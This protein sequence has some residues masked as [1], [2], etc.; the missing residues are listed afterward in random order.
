VLP[1]AYEP[2]LRPC[3]TPGR[4]AG[5]V[6]EPKYDGIRAIVEVGPAGVSP[7]LAERHRQDRQFPGI[8][9]AL[10]SLGKRLKATAVLDGEIVPSTR[11]AR[12]WL[13]AYSG[14]DPSDRAR[15]DRAR[16]TRQPPCLIVFDILRDGLKDLRR[17]PLVERRLKL[18]ERIQPRGR[19]RRGCASAKSRSTMARHVA[20]GARRRLGRPHRQ[21]SALAVPQ[22]QTVAGVA[23]DEAPETAGVR[24]RRMDAPRQTR[25]YFGS[26]L[27][28]YYDDAVSC[29]GR[30]GGDWLRS[31]ELDRVWNLLE[32]RKTD[33]RPFADNFKTAKRLRG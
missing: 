10:A 2:C 7:L 11:R 26:L 33:R 15:R 1:A 17:L 4:P 21:G 24:R 32:A 5:L 27:L 8:A 16:R 23:Q 9:T 19:N 18:Q 12:R 13:P 22:R 20:A 14:T 6:Y 30:I 3:R 25:S 28:G 29:A 31:E